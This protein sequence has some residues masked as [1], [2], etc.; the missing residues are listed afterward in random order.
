MKHLTAGPLPATTLLLMLALLITLNSTAIAQPSE[1]R[2]QACLDSNNPRECGWFWGHLNDDDEEEEEPE[3]PPVEVPMIKAP[4]EELDCTDPDQWEPSCGFVDPEG[5]FE[6]Q[7]KQRDMLLNQSV[8]NPNNP[9]T[10]ESFQRY[11]RWAVDQAITMSR[12]WEWNQIQNQDLNPLVH[13]PVSSFGLRAASR[14][15]DGKRNAVM[16]EINDQEGFL[17]WFTRTSCQFCHDMQPVMKQLARRT[18]LT[19][20]NAPLDGGCMPEFS[21]SCDTSGRSVEAAGHLAVEAV[22]DL[23]LHLP[24]DDLW[25]RVSS[26]VEA[27][28]RITSRIEV[29]FGAIQRAA[30]KGLEAV[31]D[32]RSPPVD[33]SVPDMLERSSGGLGAGIPQGVE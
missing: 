8:M 33:F 4:E 1:D 23:W 22:P 18:G 28:Q 7:A 10:V 6:F 29:F 26:G 14:T 30:E 20:Y 31:G 27:A 11:M 24:Q 9:E 32:G 13:S 21:N 17:V 5:S 25:F 12:M 16:E 2:G 19:I 15:R 3:E